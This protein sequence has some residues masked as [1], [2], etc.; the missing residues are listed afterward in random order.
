M[1]KAGVLR[2]IW[3]V[4][5]TYLIRGVT[6]TACTKYI[7][8]FSSKVRTCS[9]GTEMISLSWCNIRVFILSPNKKLSLHN[10]DIELITNP[11]HLNGGLY[12]KSI[13]PT[14]TSYLLSI[15]WCLWTL[16]YKM[17]QWPS[18][19]FLNRWKSWYRHWQNWWNK[20]FSTESI[21][22]SAFN[23]TYIGVLR[24]HGS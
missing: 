2:T 18:Y 11:R 6:K 23:T 14:K 4:E 20:D 9:L 17:F 15:S 13:V 24:Y 10:T 21:I 22:Y 7:C 16:H 12:M 1:D 8:A 5:L 3:F 19:E